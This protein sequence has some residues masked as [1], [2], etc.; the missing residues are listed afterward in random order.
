[1]MKLAKL[2]K[3]LGAKEEFPNYSDVNYWNI[4]YKKEKN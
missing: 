1:M 4:R 3:S 2:M